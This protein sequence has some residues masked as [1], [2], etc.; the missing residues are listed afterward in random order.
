[1][2]IEDHLRDALVPARISPTPWALPFSAFQQLPVAS[3][4]LD[5]WRA[6]ELGQAW[7]RL[8]VDPD[9][10]T[11]VDASPAGQARKNGDFPRSQ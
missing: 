5:Q 6:S 3:Q 1:M 11:A 8:W 4:H 2:Q 9:A 7:L 10:P